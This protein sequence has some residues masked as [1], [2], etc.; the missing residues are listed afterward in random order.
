MV[1]RSVAGWTL[2]MLADNFMSRVAIKGNEVSVL[3]SPRAVSDSG[4]E[5]V[6]SKA[7][8]DL[9]SNGLT[10]LKPSISGRPI[11]YYTS[12][13]GEFICSTHI[14]RM[15]EAGVP[16]AENA[17]ALPE[18]FVF[19]SAMPPMTLYRDIQEL[20]PGTELRVKLQVDGCEVGVPPLMPVRA[21]ARHGEG[22]SVEAAAASVH[23]ALDG[24]LRAAVPKGGRPAVLLSGGLDSSILFRKC[25][26]MHGITRSYSGAFE[27]GDQGIDNEKRYALSAASALGSNHTC[28]D[29]SVDAYLMSIVESIAAAE[30]PLQVE[31][32]SVFQLL[33]GETIPRGRHIV[34]NGQG[35]D[36]LF[37]LKLHRLVAMCQRHDKLARFLSLPPLARLMRLVANT[38]GRYQSAVETVRRWHFRKVPIDHPDHIIWQLDGFGSEKW[39]RRY[40][41]VSREQLLVNRLAAIRPY[42]DL[43]L[44][45]LIVC[46]DTIS[47]VCQLQAIWSK[48][49]ESK[50]KIFCYPFACEQIL[51]T[52]SE[53]SWP[54]KLSEPKRVLR[55]VAR[56]L[57]IPDAIIDRPKSG[58]GIAGRQWALKGGLFEPLIPL[59]AKA[60][61][62]TEIRSMQSTN[63]A[64][65][66]TFW[67]MLNYGIW[68]RL[69]INREPLA[70]LQSELAESIAA[71]GP[72]G[73]AS[74]VAGRYES[75]SPEGVAQ[76]K[77][78]PQRLARRHDGPA[79]VASAQAG[80]AAQNKH[81][82]EDSNL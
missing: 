23:D 26:D 74:A 14:S 39:T 22:G 52:V 29:V 2:T 75:D 56:D 4:E 61:D 78:S 55:L 10:V 66:F 3:E 68:K 21:S 33:S 24:V 57:G 50:Q 31:H 15:V 82:R 64:E 67:N 28:L 17:A 41:N 27:S 36:S 25:Q 48:I 49:G 59:A 8:F 60:F 1:T 5:M 51:S 72:R 63:L 65:R 77:G 7:S 16:V 45:D 62:E 70:D 80:Q 53:I 69:C 37:G 71:S 9:R 73:S 32:S 54:T 38:T 11:Y 42:A 81:A 18:F 79:P 30:V 19:R 46:I 44:D 13:Q 34:I 47:D 58:F 6:I 40:F 76:K 43:P 12:P 35:A 20:L